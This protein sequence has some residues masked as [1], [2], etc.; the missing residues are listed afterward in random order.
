MTRATHSAYRTFVAGDS[1]RM[2]IGSMTLQA[3]TAD[4]AHY[5]RRRR[6]SG[7]LGLAA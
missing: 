2:T 6:T 5:V 3:Q 1:R 4:V 7:G